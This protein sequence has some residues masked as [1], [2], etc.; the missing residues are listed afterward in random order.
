MNI[1]IN[2][3][4]KSDL[5]LD[6]FS[7]TKNNTENILYLFFEVQNLSYYLGKAF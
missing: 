3:V 7:V 5:I 4:V 6:R 1:I 2:E